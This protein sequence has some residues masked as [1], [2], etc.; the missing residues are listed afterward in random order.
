MI[1]SILK[2][3]Q[4]TGALVCN[5][6]HNLSFKI[7]KSVRNTKDEWIVHDDKF[8]PIVSKELFNKAKTK[9]EKSAKAQLPLYINKYNWILYCKDC[10][11]KATFYRNQKIRKRF[12]YV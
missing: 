9:L 5:K 8:E 11:R 3:Y 10:G 6:A 7:K 2:E 12:I 4:Y 1:Y